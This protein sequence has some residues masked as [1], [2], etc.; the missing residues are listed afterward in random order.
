MKAYLLKKF[1][2]LIPLLLGITLLTFTLIKALPGDPVLSMVGE[3]AQPEVIE[4]IKIY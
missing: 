3:R 1:F 2:I 4:M